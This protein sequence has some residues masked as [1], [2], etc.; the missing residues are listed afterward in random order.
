M[1]ETLTKEALEV[2]ALSLV[3][4]DFS[5]LYKPKIDWK[6]PQARKAYYRAKY[7][8]SRPNYVHKIDWKDPIARKAHRRE[9]RKRY[10]QDPRNRIAKNLRMRLKRFVDGKL[11]SFSEMVGCTKDDLM[12]W[13]EAQFQPGMNWGNHG[14]VWHIDHIKPV[15]AFTE[16]EI[17]AGNPHDYWNL[18]PLFAEENLR[19]GSK[20][21]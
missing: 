4:G 21:G 19:K 3:G 10:Y 6:D 8:K 20:F 13:I 15:S 1:N 2:A 11:G 14:T 17:Q 16:E 18:Q 7:R 12:K 9:W 5:H